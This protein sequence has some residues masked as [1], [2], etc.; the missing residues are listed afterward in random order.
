MTKSA[1]ITGAGSGVGA[2]VA[3]AL[4]KK[5]WRVALVG[6]RPEPLDQVASQ[7]PSSMICVC[8]VGNP[9]QVAAMGEKVLAEWG[10]V[11]A[12]VNAAGTNV[13]RRALEIL[14]LEDYHAMIDANMHGA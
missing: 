14:T 9:E 13:P 10:S 3:V 4:A 6:R 11:D 12:L 7:I 2:A 8:D 1:V 5:G